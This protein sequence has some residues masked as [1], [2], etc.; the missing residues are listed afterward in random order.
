M[1]FDLLNVTSI[2]GFTSMLIV[3]C[4]NIR[5][6]WVFPTESKQYLVRTTRSIL[7]TFNNEQQPCRHVRV[8]EDGALEKSTDVTNL[9]ADEFKKSM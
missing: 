3:F 4:E 1:D 6:L 2:H 9:L 8:E 5:T 7:G